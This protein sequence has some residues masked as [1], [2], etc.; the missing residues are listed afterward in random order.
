M[1][2]TPKATRLLLCLAAGLTLTH[3]AGIAF[4]DEHAQARKVLDAAGVKGGLVVHLGCGDG[5]LTAA[6]RANDRY[7]VHGLDVSDAK[8]Q[9][10]RGGILSQGLYG[11][12]SVSRFDGRSLPYVDNL[13]NLVVSEGPTGVPAAEVLRVLTPRGK[14]L[15]GQAKGQGGQALSAAKLKDWLKRVGQ[16]PG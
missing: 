15:L 14:A 2:T 1:L 4:A 16:C 11:K 5:K 9:Q 6:L 8:V 7:L 13:V 12:V 3:A 10:A